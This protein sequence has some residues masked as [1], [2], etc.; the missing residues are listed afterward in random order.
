MNRINFFATVILTVIVMAACQK[1]QTI[2]NIASENTAMNHKMGKPT[3]TLWADCILFNV[4]VAP[5]SFK[6]TAGNFDELY[7]S[8]NAFKDHVMSISDSKPGDTDYNGGRWHVNM[9]KS[10]V[11]STKYM[12]ACSVADLDLNDFDSTGTYFS[13]PLLPRKSSNSQ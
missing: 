3:G 5:N 9:L 4:V 7:S 10:T 13:C 11:D 6:P 8:N 1:E 12:N 2:K